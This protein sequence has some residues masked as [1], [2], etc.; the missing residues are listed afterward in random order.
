M[1][2]LSFRPRLLRRA[3]A[4]AATFAIA[5]VAGPLATTAHASLTQNCG[6]NLAMTCAGTFVHVSVL[7]STEQIAASCTAEIG[8]AASTGVHCY[9]ENGPGGP[10]INGVA[11][12]LWEPGGVATTTAVFSV[13]PSD[14]YLLCIEG[15]WVAFAGPNPTDDTFTNPV[16]GTLLID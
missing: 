14:N 10:A 7:G 6:P 9:I 15:A 2:M 12:I 4:L 3:A 5:G 16:C 13:A 1:R 8:G 11:S